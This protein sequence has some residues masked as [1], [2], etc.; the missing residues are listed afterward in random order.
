MFGNI[1]PQITTIYAKPPVSIV[2]EN[3][4]RC[5]AKL[6]RGGRQ[7]SHFT[8]TNLKVHLKSSHPKQSKELE[9]LDAKEKIENQA[10]SIK[11]IGENKQ[12]KSSHLF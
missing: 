1:F 3:G 10:G 12:M 5:E 8:T 11:N 9:D 4:K 2:E 6:S 7:P